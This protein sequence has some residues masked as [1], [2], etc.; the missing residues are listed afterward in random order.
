MAAITIPILSSADFDVTSSFWSLFGFVEKGRWTDE[1]L[2]V[3]HD[4]L[5]IE[6][7]FWFNPA[8]D[9][10]TNDVAC[11]VRFANPDEAIACHTMWADVSVP[12][13]ATFNPPVAE[14][15]GAVEFNIIDQH[16]N[17]VRLGGFP[18]S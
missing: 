5:G 1:Y 17:L 3:R 15:W 13:P 16:G 14:S 8:E 9:R 7:H 11:Y 2:I 18:P 6:L 12:E 4:D 10:W